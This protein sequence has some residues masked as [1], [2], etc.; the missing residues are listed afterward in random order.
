MKRLFLLFLLMVTSLSHAQESQ[1]SEKTE[2]LES[3]TLEVMG[4]SVLDETVS[5][6]LTVASD[7]LFVEEV[8]EISRIDSLCFYPLGYPSPRF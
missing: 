8:K 5:D 6:S 1:D 3:N 2:T 4:F 7:S